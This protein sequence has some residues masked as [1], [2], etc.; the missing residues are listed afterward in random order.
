[1]RR[2]IYLIFKEGIHN[3]AR[4][5]GAHRVEIDLDRDGDFL[6]LRIADDGHGFDVGAESDGHGL[7]SIRKRAATL[8][9]D[10][11]WR[12]ECQSGADRGTTLRMRVRLEPVRRLSLLRGG[13]SGDFR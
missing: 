9:A 13:N 12:S 5:S 2:Q 3:I 1:V 7:P 11:E 6:M 4:H 10:V 8:G